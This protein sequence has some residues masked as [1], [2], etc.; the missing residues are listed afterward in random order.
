MI[1]IYTMEEGSLI[2][3]VNG[4]IAQASHVRM[5][6]GARFESHFDPL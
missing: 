1:P 3:N 5:S 4:F 6:Y 2:Q